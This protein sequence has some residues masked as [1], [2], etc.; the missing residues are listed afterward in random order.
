MIPPATTL[1]FLGRSGCGKDTQLEFLKKK[2]E[3]FGAIGISVGALFRALAQKNTAVGR[4]VKEILEEGGLPPLWLASSLWVEKLDEEV[5]NSEIVILDGTPRRYQEAEL[6]D[7]VLEFLKRPKATAVLFE[8]S[9]QESRRRLLPR[10]RFDDTEERIKNRLAWYETE[11]LPVIDYYRSG[12]RLIEVGGEQS[13]EEVF[14]ELWERLQR[15]F[16]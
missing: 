7:Q 1:V 13:R 4:R 9:R 14:R 6:L 3:F 16:A 5:K 8:I 10:G 15:Y 2:P 12:K 11:V